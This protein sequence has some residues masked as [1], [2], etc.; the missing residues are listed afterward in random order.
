MVEIFDKV[1]NLFNWL[2]I[3]REAMQRN[4]TLRSYAVTFL[5]FA[6]MLILESQVARA[7]MAQGTPTY[8]DLSPQDFSFS[9][10]AL[11][12]VK[13]AG[14]T[15]YAPG[16]IRI[17]VKGVIE[18]IYKNASIGLRMAVVSEPVAFEIFCG[19]RLPGGSNPSCEPFQTTAHIEIW[20][21]FESGSSNVMSV[22]RAEPQ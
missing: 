21:D 5:F 20:G 11:I 3:W 14:P 9:I 6:S 7:A 17:P 12:A 19:N 2:A 4:M 13:A 10:H 22:Y 8:A 18:K 1:G 16:G 15:I